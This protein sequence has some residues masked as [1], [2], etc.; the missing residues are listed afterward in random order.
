MIAE[1]GARFCSRKMLRYIAPVMW[2]IMKTSLSSKD[3]HLCFPT[4]NR[5]FR[6]V[7]SGSQLFG[8]CLFVAFA[9]GG[10]VDIISEG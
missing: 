2:D 6:D 1:T 4:L 8:D 9:V 3:A 7:N 10:N 5:K